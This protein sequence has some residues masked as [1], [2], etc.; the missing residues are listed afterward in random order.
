MKRGDCYE[1]LVYAKISINLLTHARLAWY[2]QTT[3]VVCTQA[4]LT[5]LLSV[6]EG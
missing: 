6:G 2:E 4:A 5:H 1:N 3:E